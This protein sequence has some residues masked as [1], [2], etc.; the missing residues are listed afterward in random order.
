M[1]KTLLVCVLFSISA[2]ACNLGHAAQTLLVFGDSLSA[3]F[4]ISQAQSWP[5]LLAERLEREHYPYQVANVSISGETTSGGASRLGPALRQFKPAIVIIELGANDGLR[6]LPVQQMRANLDAMIRQSAASHARVLLVGI[7]LPPNYGVKY[8]T[9]FA[10]V[11]A[12][13]AKRHHIAFL[14]FLFDGFA[15]KRDA[16]QDD[17]LHPT[18]ASQ[19]LLLDNVWRAL[20]PL[21]NKP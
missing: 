18:A 21:L 10:K 14:P 17:G 15:G 12:D 3:G 13:L 5:T 6:G 9:D 8:T 2:C 4:G 7:R 19:P 11:Y 16:F 20:K 1:P